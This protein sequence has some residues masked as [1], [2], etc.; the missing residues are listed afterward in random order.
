V[1]DAR[2]GGNRVSRRRAWRDPT[3]LP[4]WSAGVAEGSPARPWA[5]ASESESRPGPIA[6]RREAEPGAASRTP[7]LERALLAL[8]ADARAPSSRR[9]SRTRPASRIRGTR[10]VCR[11]RRLQDS[12][13]SRSEA[14][15][16]E[17][18]V[19]SR[20][21]CSAWVSRSVPSN[22][23]RGS[24]EAT[25]QRTSS[26]SGAEDCGTQL[27]ARRSSGRRAGQEAC[28]PG[29]HSTGLTHAG[30]PGPNR[31]RTAL[32][33]EVDSVSKP[34]AREATRRRTSSRS[35]AHERAGDGPS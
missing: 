4:N 13:A 6:T 26:R 14:S 22:P 31:L 21:V 12:P 29:A 10:T 28:G 11:G 1:G 15:P 25:R 18:T 8:L 20:V 2:R 27:D 34:G 7:R 19:R 32:L 16:G 9:A 3:P 5:S 35:G 17:T 30:I 24:L 33:I 23:L